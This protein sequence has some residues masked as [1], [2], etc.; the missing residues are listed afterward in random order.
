VT[1]KEKL[2]PGSYRLEGYWGGNL[3]CEHDITIK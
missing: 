1:V 2:E 3:V